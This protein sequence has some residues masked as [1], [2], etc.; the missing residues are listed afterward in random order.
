MEGDRKFIELLRKSVVFQ[1]T[2]SVWTVTIVRIKSCP[3]S[4]IS[5]HTLRVEGDDNGKRVSEKEC[6]IS[7]HTLRVEGDEGWIAI[8]VDKIISIHTLRVEGDACRVL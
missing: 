2:P 3:F 6:I 7:I 5:I 1:S 4:I 8:D